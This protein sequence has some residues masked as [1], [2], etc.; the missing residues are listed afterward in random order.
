MTNFQFP[1]KAKFCG[2]GPQ[3]WEWGGGGWYECTLHMVIVKPNHLIGP[4]ARLRF[5]ILLC[6]TH[7]T[8]TCICGQYTMLATRNYTPSAGLFIQASPKRTIFG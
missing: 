4:P 3:N 5:I 1:S 2:G 7:Q 8:A 6:A